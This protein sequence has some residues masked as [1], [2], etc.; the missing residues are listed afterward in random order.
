MRA[1]LGVPEVRLFWTLIL[2]GV[3]GVTGCILVLAARDLISRGSIAYYEGIA[4]LVAAALLLTL[5]RFELG[6]LAVVIGVADL[7]FGLMQVF[8]LPVWLGR[9]HAQMLLDRPVAV[10]GR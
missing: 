4:R 8:G 9:T 5:G 6:T 3:L 10:D 2:C 7:L 1:S